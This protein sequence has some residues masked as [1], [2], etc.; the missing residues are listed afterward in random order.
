M[1]KQTFL[2]VALLLATAPSPALAITQSTSFTY[3]GQLQLNGQLAN[4]T[5]PASFSLFNAVTGGTQIGPTTTTSVTV[6]NGVFS[7][8]LDYPG[9]FK[10]TQLWLEIT[11]NGQ[12]LADRQLIS[13]TPVAQFALN[14][15]VSLFFNANASLADP[16]PYTT[17]AT[18][19]ALTFSA[20]CGLSGANAVTLVLRVASSIPFSLSEIV[21]TQFND[22]G[23]FTSLPVQGINFNSTP[24]SSSISSSGNYQRI[25]VSPAILHSPATPPTTDSIQ[26]Y[27]VSDARAA[28]RSCRIEGVVT[29]GF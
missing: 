21:S 18:V 2:A 23:A 19:G 8:Q 15:G 3:Q 11:I 14:G 1:I 7:T 10:G 17:L 4:G 16:P 24:I 20:S 27:L 29:P 28:Y 13:T 26:V 9:A 25:W 5:F 12:V 22:S 6:T